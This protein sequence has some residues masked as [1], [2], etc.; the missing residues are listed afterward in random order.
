[1]FEKKS[2]QWQNSVP[3]NRSILYSPVP[4]IFVLTLASERP[5]LYRNVA[6]S[7]LVLS[8]KKRYSSFMKT[9]FCFSEICFKISSNCHT[10]TCRSLKRR[11]ISKIP[12][13][14]FR[15]S[16]VFLIVVSFSIS[17]TFT[18]KCEL[19]FVS[20]QEI[21]FSQMLHFKACRLFLCYDKNQLKFYRKPS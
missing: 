5:V 20:T 16:Y 14:V 1:M 9:G 7:N 18:V 4:S 10:K 6:F 19:V 3:F 13:T 21:A 17:T 8:I 11:A 15:R 12:S 2:S